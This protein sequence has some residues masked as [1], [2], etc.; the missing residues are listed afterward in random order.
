MVRFSWGGVVPCFLAV[1]AARLALVPHGRPGNCVD[2]GLIGL[3]GG[4]RRG[5]DRGVLARK[6]TD[7]RWLA[8]PPQA[9]E[10]TVQFSSYDRA[11]RLEEGRSF[12]RSPTATPAITSASRVRASTGNGSSPR[13]R[14]PA[15]SRGSGSP[16][17]TAS[18][19]FTSTGARRRPWRR[20]SPRSPTARSRPSSAPFGHDASRGRNLYFPFPFAKS[21]K[22]TTTKGKQ[23]FQVSVT[24]L[25]E[26]TKVESYSPEVLKRA[27]AVIEETR[28]ALL[29]PAL[30]ESDRRARH[31]LRRGR[32]PAGQSADLMPNPGLRGVPA[33]SQGSCARSTPRIVRRPWPERC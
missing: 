5:G 22:I 30:H 6:M 17:L 28:R 14:G 32:I 11:T 9:G 29:H 19:G 26:G 10:R 33:Q 1:L 18:C 21:I 15:T 4:S 24:T 2:A 20:R 16:T 27:A 25:P 3:A 7:T 31:G 12:T 8:T 23:Y 13:P